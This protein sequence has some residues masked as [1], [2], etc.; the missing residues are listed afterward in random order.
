MTMY[1]IYDIPN[2]LLCGLI[3]VTMVSLSLAG[4]FVTRPFVGRML[5]RSRQF[6]DVVSYFFAAVGVFYGLALGLIAVA[7]WQNFTDVDGIAAKEAAALVGLYR[8]FD[9]YP[10]PLRQE[11]EQQLRDYTR[12]VIDVEWPKHRQGQTTGDGMLKLDALENTIMAFEPKLEREKI[13]HAEVMQSLDAVIVQRDLRVQAVNSGLP[14]ALWAVVLIGAALSIVP[15]YFFWLDNLRLHVILI[16]I[17]S[18][19]IALLIFLTAA[20]DNPFR[21]EFSVSPDAYELAYN[22]VMKKA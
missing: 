9:G 21:G 7:T 17:L 18:C 6:N 12:F 22:E 2:W 11:V 10:Q 19:F 5:D 16:T 4:L 20:M 13:S 14:A 8:D 3:V 1:W 15:T